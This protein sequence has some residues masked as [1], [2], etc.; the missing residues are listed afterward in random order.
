[1]TTP[2]PPPWY[3]AGGIVTSS[4]TSHVTTAGVTAGF[5]ADTP[6]DLKPTPKSCLTCTNLVRESDVSKRYGRATGTAMCAKYDKPIGTAATREP[7]RFKFVA[8]KVGSTCKGWNTK[9]D[10]KPKRTY[11]VAFPDLNA[12]EGS[13]EG[14]PQVNT[15]FSC[16]HFAPSDVVMSEWGWVT[17]ACGLKG[18]LVP[19]GAATYVGRKCGVS[20]FGT[21]RASL[22]GVTLLPE[23]DEE[24]LTPDLVAA[25]LSDTFDPM[26]Y[27]TDKPLTKDDEAAG[28][29]AWK[30]IVDKERPDFDTGVFLPIYDVTRYDEITL[31]KIP[32]TG[33]DEHPEDYLDHNNAIYK[34]AVLWTELDE[35]PALWGPAGVGKTEL[36][37]HIAWQ[38]QLPFERISV[39]ASTELDDL[40]GK[41]HF[42]AGKGTYFQYGRVP[43]AWQKPGIILLDEPNVGQPD[44]WQFLRPLTDNS[45]QLVLDMNEGERIPRNVDAYMG[46]AMNPAWD[47]RNVG[48]ATIGD[49]DGSRLMHL[50]MD[51]PPEQIEEQIIVTRCQHDGYTIP[52]PML[53]TVMAIARELR[54][55]CEQGTLPMSWGIRPNV[56]VARATRWFALTDAYRVAV[57]DF[58]EPQ[59]SEIVLDIVKAHNAPTSRK[60]NDSIRGF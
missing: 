42:D 50:Y 52:K 60:S 1:M 59:Q 5:G 26:T 57:A 49:A 39:T 15:C 56:K 45:K 6:P 2:P 40:A 9:A 31:A 30:K 4:T 13:G 8:D 46:M 12:P 22:L 25:F 35:T 20:E 33:D 41:M 17:G 16:K 3:A 55:M 29:R 19:E 44:V 58:L 38:M 47:P 21:K 51:L 34:I 27:P 37:R 28:I 32:K 18:E 48:A 23:Y 14:D 10:D 43:A 11:R 7:D 24:F 53:K 54:G 36:F